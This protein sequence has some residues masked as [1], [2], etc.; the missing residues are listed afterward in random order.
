M[1][2]LAAILG[3]IPTTGSLPPPTHDHQQSVK[4]FW[5]CI[6]H[7]SSAVQWY[8]QIGIRLGSAQGKDAINDNATPS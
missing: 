7:N 3:K 8:T 4:N 1:A 6:I 5:P 2:V